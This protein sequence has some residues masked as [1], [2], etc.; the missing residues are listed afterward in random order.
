MSAIR[1]RA[2]CKRVITEPADGKLAS[3]SRTHAVPFQQL[4]SPRSLSAESAI[5]GLRLE[6]YQLRL[7][8]KLGIKAVIEP[9]HDSISWRPFGV[10][11]EI[12][13]VD[14]RIPE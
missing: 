9:R 7:E 10:G 12:E 8:L 2:R 13:I 1:S 6:P 4:G 11:R 3:S 5:S 14:S